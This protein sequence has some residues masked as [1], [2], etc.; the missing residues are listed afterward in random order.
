M[1]KTQMVN[2]GMLA[3]RYYSSRVEGEIYWT[4]FIYSRKKKNKTK[5][6]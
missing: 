6:S 1:Y 5:T 3:R 2:D 4:L